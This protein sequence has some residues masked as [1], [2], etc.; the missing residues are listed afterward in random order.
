[1]EKTDIQF[2]AELQKENDGLNQMAD[3]IYLF[4]MFP[5][6]KTLSEC[7]HQFHQPIFDLITELHKKA[8]NIPIKEEA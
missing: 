7:D 3:N 1:M 5:E 4:L 2:V 8:G 6:N